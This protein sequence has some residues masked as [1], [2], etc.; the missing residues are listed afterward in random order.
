MLKK[1]SKED[2]A[3]LQ[4]WFQGWG[5]GIFPESVI[6]ENS[7][8]WIDEQRG[9]IAFAALYHDPSAK[10]FFLTFEVT[11]PTH[12]IGGTRAMPKLIAAMTDVANSIT[13]GGMI[14]AATAHKAIH[15]MLQKDGF[16]LGE[17]DVK[18]FYKP[19]GFAGESTFLEE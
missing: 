10:L 1:Y 15:G 8:F 5:W 4:K 6:P 7:Y 12:V 16:V 9:P 13:E 18:S 19:L 2:Y 11:D 3:V 17:N 14:Y